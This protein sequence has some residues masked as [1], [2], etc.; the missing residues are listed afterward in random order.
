MQALDRCHCFRLQQNPVR[1]ALHPEYSCFLSYQFRH[2]LFF[3]TTIMRIHYVERH[4][5]RVESEPEIRR[6]FQHMQ[7]DLWVLV[8]RETYIAEFSRFPGLHE[9]GIGSFVIKDSV[10]V[11][12]S[13]HLVMLNEID[14]VDLE[15]A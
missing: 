13:E 10:R 3:K 5:D 14:H 7:M 4:L 15:A 9:R 1:H 8:P 6:Y 11:F 2:H 12:V